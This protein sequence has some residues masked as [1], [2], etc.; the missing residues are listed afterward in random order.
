MSSSFDEMMGQTMDSIA[1]FDLKANV[2]TLM[3][4]NGQFFKLFFD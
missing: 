4:L 1:T 2:N 3:F